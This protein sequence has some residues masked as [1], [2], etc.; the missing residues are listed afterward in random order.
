VQ[1]WLLHVVDVVNEPHGVGVPV[2]SPAS[3]HV[4]PA[5][6]QLSWSNQ[7]LQVY[8]VPEQVDAPSVQPGHPQL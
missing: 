6:V 3:P 1:P 2:Q 8:G 7:L 5:V 4:Q